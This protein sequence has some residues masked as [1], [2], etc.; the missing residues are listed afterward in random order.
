MRAPVVLAL[1]LLLGLAVAGCSGGDGGQEPLPPEWLGRDLRK[2]GWA[3]QTLEAGWTLG[4]EYTWAAGTRVTWDWV[5]LEPIFAH[6]QLVKMDAPGGPRPLVANDA[7]EGVGERTVV[8]SGV[9]QVDWMNEWDRP[10]TI[11]YKVP[12]GG[13][14]HLYPP[15]QGPGCL[16]ATRSAGSACLAPGLPVPP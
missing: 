13:T 5:V 9:H 16:F 15:G 6:F 4:M 3:N 7:Q 10:I 14:L 2:P 11:A 1:A 12:A 8:E